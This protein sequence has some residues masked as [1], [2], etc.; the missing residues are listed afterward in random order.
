VYNHDLDDGMYVDFGS[1]N[2]KEVFGNIRR[3]IRNKK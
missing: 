1:N 3:Y 2:E